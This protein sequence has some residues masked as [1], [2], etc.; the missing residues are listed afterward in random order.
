M[1]VDAPNASGIAALRPP[2]R[3]GADARWL[4]SCT[5]PDGML[6]DGSISSAALLEGQRRA[7]REAT[8]GAPLTRVLETLV[9]TL[10]R[11]A[12]THVRA[13]ILLVSRDGWHL[14][15]G[16]APSLPA[17]YNAAI[18]GIRIGP[19]VGSCGT[20][21]F[22]GRPVVVS[23][24]TTD[25]LWRDFRALAEKHGLRACWSVPFHS[26]KKR[27]LGTFAVYHDAPSTPS[28]KDIELVNMLG[29]TAS[30]VV[31]R[32]RRAAEAPLAAPVSRRTEAVNASE[33]AH[34]KIAA[35]LGLV[36]ARRLVD[37]VVADVGGKL[38][39]ADD[40]LRFADRLAERRGFEG[41]LG[42]MLSVT[43][44]MHGAK[45]A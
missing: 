5:G 28:A 19:S 6:V 43:A 26:L 10:E 2:R 21:A 36:A 39:T 1:A 24:I 44:V 41:A 11:N 16:V 9:S 32:A 37:E 33:I 12:S 34:E 23:D 18:E 3:S 35:V 40:L 14:G 45:R 13:S 42:A 30:T 4:S 20:A 25:P 31:E 29:Q 17:E 38:E 8:D 22:T 27:V 7:L 15:E